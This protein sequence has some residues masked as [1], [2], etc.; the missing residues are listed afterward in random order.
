MHLGLR[1]VYPPRQ[2]AFRELAVGQ[3][4]PYFRDDEG[5]Q[6]AEGH[7]NAE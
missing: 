7:G 3:A 4:K 2:L 5:E 6:F 1:E